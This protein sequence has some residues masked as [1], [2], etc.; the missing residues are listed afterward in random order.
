MLYGLRRFIVRAFIAAALSAFTREAASARAPPD[1]KA[2]EREATAALQAYLRID[3]SNLPGDVT[4][5]A[6]FL[7]ILERE[8]IP[9]KR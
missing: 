3:T 5:A 2:L 9:V 1:W 4:N 7:A 6:D 8:G